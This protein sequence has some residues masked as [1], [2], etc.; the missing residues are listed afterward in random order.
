MKIS[1][2]SVL[3]TV[4]E[5]RWRR[6][7]TILFLSSLS[8]CR[9][10]SVAG[11]F[12]GKL[13]VVLCWFCVWFCWGM[14]W[15]TDFVLVCCLCSLSLLCGVLSCSRVSYFYSF[16]R[17]VHRCPLLLL[18]MRL[19]SLFLSLPLEPTINHGRACRTSD[20]T[21]RKVEGCTTTFVRRRAT[22]GI[23]IYEETQ[24]IQ[25]RLRKLIGRKWQGPRP[26]CEHPTAVV[27]PKSWGW[28]TNQFWTRRSL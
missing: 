17:A 1:F 26:Q 13:I 16:Y 10:H 18:Y 11:K 25:W 8:L 3:L 12:F 20:V 19:F 23:G 5:I 7:P 22:F 21:E 15:F 24:H 27:K 9:H 4:K 6:W 28:C 2:Y 14:G